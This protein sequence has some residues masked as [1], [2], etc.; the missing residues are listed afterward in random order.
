MLLFLLKGYFGKTT[1][2]ILYFLE[3]NSC[4]SAFAGSQVK[5]LL[6]LVPSLL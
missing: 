6:N 5:T 3:K 1:E 2:N 4:F